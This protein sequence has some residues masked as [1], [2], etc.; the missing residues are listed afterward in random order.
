MIIKSIH[1]FYRYLLS[2]TAH[3]FLV[4]AGWLPRY[5]PALY[6]AA[7]ALGWR[8]RAPSGPD[9]PPL[10]IPEVAVA[11]VVGNKLVTT[12]MEPDAA[13]GN[14]SGFEL[15]V[16][17]GVIRKHRP[18]KIF[19]IGTF[20]GRTTLNMAINMNKGHVY[21]LDLPASKV[22]STSLAIAPGDERFVIKEESGTRFRA[23]AVADRIT[24]LWGD[25]ATFDFTPWQGN[26]DLVFIDGAHSCEYVK[27]D[28][29]NALKLL[30][31]EG[32]VILWHDYGSPW[33]K[34]L[35]K[36]MNELCEKSP[37]LAGMQH[38]KGTTLVVLE[39]KADNRQ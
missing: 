27:K 37:G 25:S 26:I 19:E 7:Y 36:A 38:L 23:T 9:A 2:S 12:V 20:D 5:R 33:W 6:E 32:G 4:V 30:K 39:T 34:G 24:Q 11:D 13:N 1:F 18:Q 28:T 8:K 31:P 16:I 21:T 14:V 3:L 22:A 29:E 10:S 17:A 35:T 15:L